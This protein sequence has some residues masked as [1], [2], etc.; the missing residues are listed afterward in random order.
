[1]KKLIVGVITVCVLLVV[2]VTA[3]LR[4]LRGKDGTNENGETI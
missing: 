2:S 4:L 1:M 3:T